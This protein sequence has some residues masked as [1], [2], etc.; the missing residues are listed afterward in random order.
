MIRIRD[1]WLLA[2]LSAVFWLAAS[3]WLPIFSEMEITGMRVIHG[4]TDVIG[5]AAWITAVWLVQK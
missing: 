4:V 5:F 2:C 3:F 1:I